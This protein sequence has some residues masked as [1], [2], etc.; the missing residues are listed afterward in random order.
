MAYVT[1]DHVSTDVRLLSAV[2]AKTTSR[3]DCDRMFQHQHT[4]SGGQGRSLLCRI[5]TFA[6]L[7]RGKKAVLVQEVRQL[8]PQRNARLWKSAV[9]VAAQFRAQGVG[10]YSSGTSH[11]GVAFSTGRSGVLLKPI[12]LDYDGYISI[13]VSALSSC[14]PRHEHRCGMT[15]PLPHFGNSICSSRNLASPLYN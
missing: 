7:F 11:T 1:L 12:M 9:R 10:R 2:A 6:M 3:N 15:L 13:S 14:N 4:G 8:D 5:S